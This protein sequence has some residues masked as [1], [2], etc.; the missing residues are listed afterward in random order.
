MSCLYIATI[1]VLSIGALVGL[2]M[3]MFIDPDY[4]ALM[5]A[6]V[7]CIILIGESWRLSK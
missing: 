6:C 4:V 2:F 7:L 1:F 3:A 5:L